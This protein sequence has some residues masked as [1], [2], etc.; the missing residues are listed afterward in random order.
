M[1]CYNIKGV[2]PIPKTVKTIGFQ[3][4]DYCSNLKGVITSNN[5]KKIDSYA[6][7]Y[8]D[9]GTPIKNFVIYGVKDSAAHRYAKKNNFKF[10]EI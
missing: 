4:F 3:A 6:F 10:V 9:I 8:A 7:G 2:L 5:L 1:S